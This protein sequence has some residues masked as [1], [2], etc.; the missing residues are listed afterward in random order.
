[1]HL[2]TYQVEATLSER[3]AIADIGQVSPADRR[4][5]D[6]AAR[7]GRLVKYRGHWDTLSPDFGIGPLKSCWA[8]PEAASIFVGEA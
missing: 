5:L 4:A 2:T 6:K 1:M 8:L 3:G 7:E